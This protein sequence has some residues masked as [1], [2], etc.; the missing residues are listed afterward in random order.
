MGPLRYLWAGPW[1]LVGAALAPAVALSGGRVTVHDGVL[2]LAGGIL[3]AIL[4]RLPPGRVAAITVGHAVLAVDEATLHQTR[5]HERV[6]VTQFER[7]GL[8]FP[9]VYGLASWTAW[10]R[11]QHYYFDNRFEREAREGAPPGRP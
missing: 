7:W 11:G 9:V 3:P 4:R 10:Q 1:T 5:D 8:F 2:E 6:H